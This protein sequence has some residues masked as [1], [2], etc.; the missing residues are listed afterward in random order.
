MEARSLAGLVVGIRAVQVAARS[1]VGA[2]SADDRAEKRILAGH[3]VADQAAGSLAG[4]VAV[5]TPADLVDL[6]GLEAGKGACCG[7]FP[8]VACR[9]G[10]AEGMVACRLAGCRLEEIRLA[11]GKED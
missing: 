9:P 7:S 4:H 10:L 5:R 8:A 11:E 1:L 2:G 3:C 6:T